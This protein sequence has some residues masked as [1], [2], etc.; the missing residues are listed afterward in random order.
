MKKARWLL[1]IGLILVG[2]AIYW[3]DKTS[4]W[5]ES[6]TKVEGQVIEIVA[7]HGSDSTTY[8]PKIRYKDPKG[9]FREFEHPIS[10]SPTPFEV[11][12]SVP[13]L[14]DPEN[15]EPSLGTFF[16]LYFIGVASGSLGLIMLGVY[17]LINFVGSGYESRLNKL[18]RTGVV[19]EGRVTEVKQANFSVNEKNPWVVVVDGQCPVTFQPRK[20]ESH[21]IFDEPKVSVGSLVKVYV[22]RSKPKKYCIDI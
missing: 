7:V 5:V 18:K 3:Y 20:F 21:Y 4:R 10:Q 19:V 8:K 22:D 11:G 2:F 16:G 15:S 14:L 1:Y 9:N 6:A 13:V 17:W 12:E